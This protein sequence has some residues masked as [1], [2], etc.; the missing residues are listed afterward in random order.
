[1]ANH[2]TFKK[3][4]H[5]E[6]FNEF[7]TDNFKRSRELA[8]AMASMGPYHEGEA[9]EYIAFLKEAHK[10]RLHTL[11]WN[12]QERMAAYAASIRCVCMCPW[13]R[14]VCGWWEVMCVGVYV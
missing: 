2:I 6:V 9:V 11:L 7:L 13:W 10:H 12:N 1:M 4:A 5:M 3:E 8:L 14:N